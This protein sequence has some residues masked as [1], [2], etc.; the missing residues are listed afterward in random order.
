LFGDVPL[1]SLNTAADESRYDTESEIKIIKRFK[2]IIE[3]EKPLFTFKSK[4]QSGMEVDDSEDSDLHSLPDDDIQSTS[5]QDA[6]DE[7]TNVNNISD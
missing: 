3:D 1:E 7:E 5:D 2:P 4:E 6:T